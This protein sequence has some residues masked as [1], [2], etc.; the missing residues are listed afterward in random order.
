[1]MKTQGGEDD[2]GEQRDN[3]VALSG[4]HSLPW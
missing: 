2:D 4:A 1:M 3:T